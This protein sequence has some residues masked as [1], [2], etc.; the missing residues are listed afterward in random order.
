MM[1]FVIHWPGDANRVAPLPSLHPCRFI[2]ELPFTLGVNGWVYESEEMDDGWSVALTFDEP[3]EVKETLVTWRFEDGE[4]GQSW[5]VTLPDAATVQADGLLHGPWTSKHGVLA[6]LR[7]AAVQ[8]RASWGSIESKYDALLA[9]N[10]DPSGPADRRVIM[11]LV[12]MTLALGHDRIAITGDAVAAFEHRGRSLHWWFALHGIRFSAALA[13]GDGNALRLQWQMLSPAADDVKLLIRPALD[14]RSFHSV[15]K[16]FQG[17]EATFPAALTPS[18][19]GFAFKLHDGHL[20]TVASS[21]PFHS[22]LRW[23]YCVPLP[24][25]AARGLEDMTD[26]FSPGEFVWN[27]AQHSQCDLTVSVDGDTPPDLSTQLIANETPLPQAMSASLELY[28]SQRGEDLTVIAGYPWFL[29]WGRDSLI[30]T[31]GLLAEGRLAEAGSILRRFGS[32]EHEGTLPNLLRGAEVTNRETSDAPLWWIVA[33]GEWIALG[34]DPHTDCAGRTLLDIMRSIASHYAKGTAAGVCMDPE[35]ALIF[36]PAHFTWMDTDQPCGTPRQGYPIEIQALWI[37]ALRVLDQHDPD[38]DWRGWCTQAMEH[39]DDLFW[40]EDLEHFADCLHI[41]P[42]ESALRAMPDDHLRPNQ[43]LAITLGAISDESHAQRALVSSQCLLVPG[44]ARSLA[45]RP[46]A[47]HVPVLWAGES[48]ND[49]A[50]PY[51]PRYTGPEQVSRKPAYHNGT[52]WCWQYPLFAEAMVKA[53][54]PGHRDA[55]RRLMSA[56]LLPWRDGCVGQLPEITDGDMPH[57]Q[58][59]CGAQAWSISEWLR[60]WRL[61]A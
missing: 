30:F 19:Q 58:R 16:A 47:H 11:P 43:W 4:V 24:V 28:L 59:G 32:F 27:I 48:L 49:P 54:G 34:G 41:G 60:V 57:L 29:D 36:S 46:V 61:L 25:E 37:A 42:G 31:R 18:K 22:D 7:G 20:V 44:A 55:A 5:I 2:A 8:A 12:E 1:N 26:V 50:N 14:D 40:D 33:A 45:P 6:N 53:H 38:G 39:L 17:A 9:A 35:T 10:L 52:A 51:F 21:E 15:T 13:L 56:S 3:I 23:H